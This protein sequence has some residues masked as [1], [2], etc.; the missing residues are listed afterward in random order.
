[1]GL[2]GGEDDCMQQL[3]KS[4]LEERREGSEASGRRGR[5]GEEMGG[6]GWVGGRKHIM[7]MYSPLVCHGTLISPH[8]VH[9]VAVQSKK[10]LPCLIE[11]DLVAT[12]HFRNPADQT[13]ARWREAATN[14]TVCCDEV[15]KWQE[16]AEKRLACHELMQLHIH[17]RELEQRKR[18]RSGVWS[19]V[20]TH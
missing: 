20:T 2:G 6:K 18:T 19:N 10:Q 8:Q 16:P 1:M 11:R 4:L 15:T 14:I 12:Q 9:P 3:R 17:E 7:Y 13:T 5:G